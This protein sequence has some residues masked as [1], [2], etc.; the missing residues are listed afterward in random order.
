MS[1]ETPTQ[2]VFR[3][4]QNRKCRCYSDSFRDA[5]HVLMCP[6]WAPTNS[7]SAMAN[8]LLGIYSLNHQVRTSC[9]VQ[10]DYTPRAR[11]SAQRCAFTRH[12][13]TMLFSR[14]AEKAAGITKRVTSAVSSLVTVSSPAEQFAES[15]CVRALAMAARLGRVLHSCRAV[16][17][18]VCM[19]M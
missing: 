17:A 4:E 6:W 13:G 15:W 3:T 9:V 16:Y 19:C 1:R 14:L 5:A 7:L 18:C 2:V 10:L 12:R 11:G 8:S